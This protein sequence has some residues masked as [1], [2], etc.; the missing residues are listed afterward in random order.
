MQTERFTWW[1]L[2][3]RFLGAAVR[4]LQPRRLFF[5]SLGALSVF[6]G[7]EMQGVVRPH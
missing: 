3:F 6:G 1:G 2:L 4:D 5:L 7:S